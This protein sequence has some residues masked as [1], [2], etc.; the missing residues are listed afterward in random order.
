MQI[1]DAELDVLAVLWKAGPSTATEVCELLAER[2]PLTHA[3]VSTLLRRLQQK[4]LVEFDK[5]KQGKAFLFRATRAAATRKQLARDFLDRVFDGC[6]VELVSALFGSKLPT[7]GELD[8]LEE[9]LESLRQR[10][11]SKKRK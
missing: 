6:G 9:I 7:D 5:A 11:Q 2:R 10:Q 1:P 8:R 3:S 4:G